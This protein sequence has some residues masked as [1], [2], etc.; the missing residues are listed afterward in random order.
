MRNLLPEG[1]YPG[2]LDGKEEVV[3]RTNTFRVPWAD[4]QI[5][6]A[7]EGDILYVANRFQVAAYNLA[8]GQ[9]LWQSP[10]PPGP[11]KPAQDWAMI[12]KRPLITATHIFVR[13]L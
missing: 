8:S 2:E 3:R 5:A 10:P 11:L 9:R 13:Q 7:L 4:R 12:P 6:T 1:V